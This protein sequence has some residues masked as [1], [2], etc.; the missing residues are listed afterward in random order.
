MISIFFS[1][2]K[3]MNY[4]N[5]NSSVSHWTLLLCKCAH[6]IQSYALL[7]FF[8]KLIWKML[9]QPWKWMENVYVSWFV[10][11][12]SFVNMSEIFEIL[13]NSFANKKCSCHLLANPHLLWHT[14]DGKW[15]TWPINTV[16][17]KDRLY[18]HSC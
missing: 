2:L 10:A 17:N 15:L 11:I 1:E 18:M 3:K 6:L 14:D 8:E 5:I 16:W 12:C 7:F 9:L 4:P 13:Y